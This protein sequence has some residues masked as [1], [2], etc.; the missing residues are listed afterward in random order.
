M[1]RKHFE[2]IAAD[3][4]KQTSRCQGQDRRSGAGTQL[5]ALYELALRLTTTFEQS[6][7]RF[8]SDRFL[9]ACGF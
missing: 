6:N 2:A 7:D 5:E 9:K 4:A 1:T 8:D 3:F